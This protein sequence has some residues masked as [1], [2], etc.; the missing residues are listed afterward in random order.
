MDDDGSIT[1]EELKTRLAVRMVGTMAIR[2]ES[3]VAIRA[4][5]PHLQEFLRRS[6]LRSPRKRSGCSGTIRTRFAL[7]ERS[8]KSVQSSEKKGWSLKRQ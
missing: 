1:L 5:Y 3:H 2:G 8:Q 6:R 4:E 7:P